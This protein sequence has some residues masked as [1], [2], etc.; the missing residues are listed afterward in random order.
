VF[1][2]GRP[3]TTQGQEDFEISWYL[4]FQQ[5]DGAWAGHPEIYAD[6][7]C[8]KVDI[9]IY[10][11]DYTTLGGSLVFKSAGTKEELACNRAMIHVSYHDNNHFNSVR[12]SIS[13]QA[14][15]PV[16]LGGAE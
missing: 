5:K 4:F 13:S 9:T 8:Y 15:G 12:Q 10:S 11:K 1:T 2:Q 16:H 7:W 14:N 3:G 6:A